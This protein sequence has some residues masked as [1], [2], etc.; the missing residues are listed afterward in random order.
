MSSP[1]VRSHRAESTVFPFSAI[2]FFLA[3]GAAAV[4]VLA[5]V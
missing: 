3:V 2:A 1:F 4:V 5:S